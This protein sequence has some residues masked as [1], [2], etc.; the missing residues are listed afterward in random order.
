MR[1]STEPVLS[2]WAASAPKALQ[3]EKPQQGDTCTPQLEGDPRS[4]QLEKAGAQR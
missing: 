3:P 1:H 4:L 2:R